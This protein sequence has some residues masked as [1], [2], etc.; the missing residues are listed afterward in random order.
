MP[1]RGVKRTNTSNKSDNSASNDLEVKKPSKKKT[2]KKNKNIG[3]GETS[4]DITN[5]NKPENTTHQDNVCLNDNFVNNMNQQSFSQDNFYCPSPS[6]MFPMPNQQICSTPNPGMMAPYMSTSMPMNMPMQQIS[7]FSQPN[8][9]QRPPW[10]DEIFKRMDKFEN[11]LNKIEQIDSVVTKLNTKVN[12][13]EQCT[14][15]FDGKLDQV[16]KSTQLISDEFDSQKKSLS[17]FKREVDKLTKQ[18][19]LNKVSMDSIEKNQ[20]YC[21]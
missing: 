20:R 19:N 5:V 15:R 8:Y 18:L 7:P 2:K 13:L 4:G 10:V 12:K 1:R 16:E 6:N 17:E 14:E 9:Q 21:R 3:K 11:K